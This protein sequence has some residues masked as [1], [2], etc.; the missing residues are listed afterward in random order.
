MARHAEN[1][2]MTQVLGQVAAVGAEAPTIERKLELIRF[3]RTRLNGDGCQLDRYLIEQIERKGT[4][5]VEAGAELEDL[6]SINESLA[7]LPWHPA[8]F[9]RPENLPDG[10]RALVS[11]GGHMRLV[12]LGPELDLGALRPGD[13]VFLSAEMNAILG[14]ASGELLR[15]G[16]IANFDHALDDGRIAIRWREEPLIVSTAAALDSSSLRNGDLI[17]FDRDTGLA[18]EKIEPAN[19][20]E[21]FLKESPRESLTDVGGLDAVV[22]RIRQVLRLH[23]EHPDLVEKYRLPR[24]GSILFFGPPGTG[25]T[26]LAKAIAHELGQRAQSGRSQF[27]HIKPGELSSMWYGETESNFRELFRIARKAGEMEPAVPVVIFFDEVDAIGAARSG[28]E[29]GGLSDRVH[30]HVLN[31]FFAELDG[32][33]SRG[34]VLVIA[35][36]NR[37]DVLDPALVRPG[38]LGD[39]R[40]EIPRPNMAAARSIFARHLKAD[41]PYAQNGHG[42]NL[43]ATRDEIIERAVSHI[44]APQSAATLATITFRDGRQRPIQPDDLVSGAVIAG[45]CRAAVERACHRERETGEHGVRLEDVLAALDDEFCSTARQLTPGN[46]HRYLG[47]LPQDMGVAR[48]E[49]A[50]RRIDRPYRY[51][52]L[53]DFLSEGPP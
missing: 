31:S 37:L 5:L 47:G 1:D 22:A 42:A 39:E 30:D 19:G 16:E 35:A 6:R 3:A 41:V 29:G 28:T 50:P 32:L 34:N 33:Q 8:V 38:R 12:G 20:R 23:F 9:L 2:V 53:S 36:T 44:F 49:Q 43:A 10:P 26:L 21:R 7:A 15:V 52:M 51:V 24:L 48:V 25:K 14:I 13:T 46:C 17:R 18:V 27:I 11:I 40:I 45:V 4:A